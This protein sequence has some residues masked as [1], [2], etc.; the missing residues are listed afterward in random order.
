M[1][2]SVTGLLQTAQNLKCTDMHMIPCASWDI[3][4]RGTGHTNEQDLQLYHPSLS[5]D[6]A[7][8]QPKSQHLL[9]IHNNRSKTTLLY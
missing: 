9:W 3:C 1:A 7:H 5:S 6:L 4:Y 8:H 2:H